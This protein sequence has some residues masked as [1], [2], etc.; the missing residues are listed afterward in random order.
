MLKKAYPNPP[1][2]LNLQD[3]CRLRYRLDRNQLIEN[4]D[5]LKNDPYKFVK[6]I[7]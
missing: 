4:L 1:K 5:L 3:F 7:I 6:E 2:N